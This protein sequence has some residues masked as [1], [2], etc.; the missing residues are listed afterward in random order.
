MVSYTGFIYIHKLK[1]GREKQREY[2]SWLQKFVT[3]KW[4]SFEEVP[5]ENVHEPI[6]KE[7]KWVG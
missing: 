6:M 7:Q 3:Q 2:F 4:D 5:K 1:V